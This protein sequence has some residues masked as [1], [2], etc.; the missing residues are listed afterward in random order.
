MYDRMENILHYS[1]MYFTCKKCALFG[2]FNYI[3]LF[4]PALL[5]TVCLTND[6]A[7]N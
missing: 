3:C 1:Y 7:I 4:D 6:I 2:A 5:H